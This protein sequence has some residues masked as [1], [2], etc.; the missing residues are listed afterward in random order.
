[1]ENTVHRILRGRLN[2]NYDKEQLVE[3]TIKQ[4]TREPTEG[5]LNIERI[6]GG[7]AIAKKNDA[8]NINEL[9]ISEEQLLESVKPFVEKMGRLPYMREDDIVVMVD[10]E[11][12]SYR[13]VKYIK[14]YFGTTEKMTE[15]LL[16]KKLLTFKTIS[17]TIGLEEKRVK[18]LMSGKA[19]KINNHERR[20]IDLFLNN[21]LYKDL[22]HSTSAH[23]SDCT[24]TKKCGQPYW[25][26]VVSCPDYK[27]GKKAK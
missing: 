14:G 7:V 1:M 20:M 16:E 10:D 2:D 22:E 13:A 25:V 23:C 12:R 27:K 6:K 17:D 8:P 3:A 26:D 21:D 5:L 18:E 19:K 24:K 9:V 11:A 4:L 15:Y